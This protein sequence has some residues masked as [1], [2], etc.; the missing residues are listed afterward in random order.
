[1]LLVREDE[2]VLDPALLILGGYACIG[3]EVPPLETPG[4]VVPLV[5]DFCS[6]GVE[7]LLLSR[8]FER[9]LGFSISCWGRGR[10]PVLASSSSSSEGT[11]NNGSCWPCSY[12]G[13]E[14][15]D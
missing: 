4:A 15:S 13:R 8:D 14:E 3:T 11:P 9:G 7:R 10:L 6:S 1:M 2:G 12:E 5:I